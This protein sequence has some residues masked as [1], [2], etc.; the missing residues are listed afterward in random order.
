MSLRLVR[1]SSL[2]GRVTAQVSDR[3]VEA[4]SKRALLWLQTRRKTVSTL[5]K[6]HQSVLKG[7]VLKLLDDIFRCHPIFK[8]TSSFQKQPSCRF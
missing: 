6:E 8:M 3:T 4:C 7:S 1:R 2:E 5:L